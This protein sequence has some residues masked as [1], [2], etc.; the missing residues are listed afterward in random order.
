ML[1]N[2]FFQSFFITSIKHKYAIRRQWL[3]SAT[4][5]ITRSC[6]KPFLI[7]L[8]MIRLSIT[9]EE[10]TCGMLGRTIFD[11][12]FLRKTTP[13]PD[14]HPPHVATVTHS[15]SSIYFSFPGSMFNTARLYHN[16]LQSSVLSVPSAE[17]DILSAIL[18]QRPKLL[19]RNW[20]ADHQQ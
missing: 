3:P 15:P 1:Q 6:R 12:D 20:P 9:E 10:Q 19:T 16:M 2:A 7:R 14:I 4:L 11:H 5:S 8:K 17:E 13:L 18:D